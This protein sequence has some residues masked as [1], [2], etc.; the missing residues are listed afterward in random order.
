M[1]QVE[2]RRPLHIRNMQILKQW[3]ESNEEIQT[4]EEEKYMKWIFLMNA[5]SLNKYILS[6]F[7]MSS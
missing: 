7:Y 4:F 1:I 5:N 3:G 2:E 6:A